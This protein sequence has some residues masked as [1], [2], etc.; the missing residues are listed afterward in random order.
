MLKEERHNFILNE[1]HSKPKV[2]TS[3]LSLSLKV[4]EDT[5]RRDLKELSEIGQ[6]HKVH[7]GAL[8]PSHNPF[9]Y[10]DRQVYALESKIIIAEKAKSLIKDGQVI[11]MDGGT[12][13]LELVRRLPLDLKSTVFTNS[14]PVAVQLSEHPNIEVIFAGGKLLKDAQATTG[15][16][17]IE[18]FS[19]IRA[20]I[21]ILGTRSLDH[22]A[23]ITEIDWEEAKV[24][25]AIVQASR[26]VVSL[27][28]S[29]KIDTVHAYSVCEIK[30]LQTLITELDV[31]D[32]MLTPYREKGI[33]LL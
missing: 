27:A 4:S 25:R 22:E 1:L 17:V 10:R 30:Q 19:S 23:G 28:I 2:L 5:I 18:V 14:L 20:D 29:E 33:E 8:A 7:G 31:N 16:E 13:N 21:G 11:L 9:S 12:T 24:K 6:V 15:M 26:R 3:E 32:E